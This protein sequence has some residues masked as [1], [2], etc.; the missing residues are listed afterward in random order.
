MCL[1]NISKKSVSDG[2]AVMYKVF[3]LSYSNSY[4]EYLMLEK[5][6]RTFL[7]SPFER[8]PLKKDVI[9]GKAEYAADREYLPAPFFEEAV[10]MSSGSINQG[11]VH[12]YADKQSALRDLYGFYA[13]NSEAAVIVKCRI[14]KGETYYDGTFDEDQSCR[15]R[16]TRAVIV[17]RVEEMYVYR[18]TEEDHERYGDYHVFVLKDQGP[19]QCVIFLERMYSRMWKAS[20]EGNPYD[21]ITAAYMTSDRIDECNLPDLYNQ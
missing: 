3:V 10:V 15:T 2:D 13:R 4:E 7:S 8:T 1:K 14:P 16:A 21:E 19:R 5:D 18:M 6:E 9:D 12:G 11:F 20:S 17:E